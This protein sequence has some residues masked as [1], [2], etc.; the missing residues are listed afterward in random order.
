[1]V[2][3]HVG[4]PGDQGTALS[5]MGLEADSPIEGVERANAGLNV[6]LGIGHRAILA[7]L[8]VLSAQAS[9][10]PPPGNQGGKRPS[11]CS[12]RA[13]RLDGGTHETL[14]RRSG[15]VCVGSMWSERDPPI[16]VG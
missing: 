7:R 15:E 13:S 10:K 3:V 14:S 4:G 2:V 8:A 9:C 11:R 6:A 1:M 12:S 5:K 16:R